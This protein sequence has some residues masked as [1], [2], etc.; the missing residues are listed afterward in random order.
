MEPSDGRIFFVAL[1][2]ESAFYASKDHRRR[3][4]A[5]PASALTSAE[6]PGR[7]AGWPGDLGV[8]RLR[9]CSI[10]ESC[11][12]QLLNYLRQILNLSDVNSSGMVRP[13][14]VPV[15]ECTSP[16]NRIE[17]VCGS[18]FWSPATLSIIALTWLSNCLSRFQQTV[19]VS[20]SPLNWSSLILAV[21]PVRVIEAVF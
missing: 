3:S 18:H 1:L 17:F 10:Q 20:R 12:S 19:H 2:S 14:H 21:A 11:C 8:K 16:L 13:T 7:R 9:L 4:P 6:V 15:L 5:T